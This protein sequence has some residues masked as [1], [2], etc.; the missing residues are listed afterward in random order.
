MSRPGTLKKWLTALLLPP[1]FWLL[2]DLDKMA[3]AGTAP[4]AVRRTRPGVEQARQPR[5]VRGASLKAVP[6][7]LRSTNRL[8][9]EPTRRRA[10]LRG[11]L[12]RRFGRGR[13]AMRIL[14][15]CW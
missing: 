13:E 6:S 14:Q 10:V 15:L 7:A 8:L 9:G 4:A 11:V 2:C 3:F 5:E 1:L 12:P